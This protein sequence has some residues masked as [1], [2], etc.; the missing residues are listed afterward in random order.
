MCRW[1]RSP[2]TCS[3]NVPLDIHLHDDLFLLIA[4]FL[5]SFLHSF[6]HTAEQ[7]GVH[8][9]ESACTTE[10]IQVCVQASKFRVYSRGS[11]PLSL[12]LIMHGSHQKPELLPY[13]GYHS[14]APFKILASKPSRLQRFHC[15]F[16]VSTPFAPPGPSRPPPPAQH[17]PRLAGPAGPAWRFSMKS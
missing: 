12:L 9:R 3:C 6:I 10:Q 16:K 1:V 4:S 14:L 17:P 5:P 8:N 7:S 13:L 11:A 2:H 15:F